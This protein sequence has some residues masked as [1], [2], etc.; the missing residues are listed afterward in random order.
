MNVQVKALT[1]I[2]KNYLENNVY[3]SK[4]IHVKIQGKWINFT[5]IQKTKICRRGGRK[6]ADYKTKYLK[7]TKIYHQKE[8]DLDAF[9]AEFWQPSKNTEL[10]YY[11]KYFRAQK[12]QIGCPISSHTHFLKVI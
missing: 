5:K 12:K 8:P 3:Y 2:K 6:S 11:V 10:L 4:V 9:G 1:K 7:I